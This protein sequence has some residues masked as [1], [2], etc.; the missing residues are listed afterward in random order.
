MNEIGKGLKISLRCETVPN[1]QELFAI[2]PTDRPIKS[3]ASVSS[4]RR[5]G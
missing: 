2:G 5:R 4:S 3:L 1:M